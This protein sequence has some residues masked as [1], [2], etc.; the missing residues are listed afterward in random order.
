MH[1][2]VP[3]RR[4]VEIPADGSV[5]FDLAVSSAR[6]ARKRRDDNGERERKRVA[7]EEPRRGAGQRGTIAQVG[8]RKETRVGERRMSYHMPRVDTLAPSSPLGAR[9]PVPAGALALT[10]RRL[11]HCRCKEKERGR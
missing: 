9:A 3:G 10:K 1:D 6:G 8:S 11:T 5:N 2:N 4:T 7:L